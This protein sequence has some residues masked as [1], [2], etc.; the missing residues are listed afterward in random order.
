MAAPVSGNIANLAALPEI[1]TVQGAPTTASTAI[2]VV[3]TVPDII[4]AVGK[5]TI[6]TTTSVSCPRRV[7]VGCGCADMK[8]VTSATQ[9]ALAFAAQVSSLSARDAVAAAAADGG[10]AASLLAQEPAKAMQCAQKRWKEAASGVVGHIAATA[11][12][13]SWEKVAVL[14]GGFVLD[15][16]VDAVVEA[17][18]QVSSISLAS[19]VASCIGSTAR[20]AVEVYAASGIGRAVQGCNAVF[21][22]GEMVCA[23]GSLVVSEGVSMCCGVAR[24][25][26]VPC[27]GA[28]QTVKF[29]VDVF[30]EDVGKN[31]LELLEAKFIDGLFTEEGNYPA[32]K[33]SL[34]ARRF[35]FDSSSS[36]G[37]IEANL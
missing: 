11:K 21:F 36:S 16:I 22:G 17:G 25:S 31:G 27:F 24:A 4:I 26:G 5:P 15:G 18:L 34:I 9:D 13:Q 1:L 8:V 7:E 2:A 28:V 12:T 19:P 20:G 33:A 37:T 3:T 32:A 29:G 30:L 23:D 10:H 14:G 35:P 6:T